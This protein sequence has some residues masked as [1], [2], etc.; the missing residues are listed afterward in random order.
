MAANKHR[1]LIDISGRRFG[2][3]VVMRR[4]GSHHGHALWQC[5]CDCGCVVEI[6]GTSLRRGRTTSCGCWFSERAAARAAKRN[7]R[8]G[9]R[10]TPG[11]LPGRGEGV[12]PR[13]L[14]RVDLVGAGVVAGRAQP[15]RLDGSSQRGLA[16]LREP[17]RLS[18]R[19]HGMQSPRRRV[20]HVTVAGCTAAPVAIDCCRGWLGNR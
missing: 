5:K 11:G 17:R 1:P 8:H 20:R 15:S 7:Y 4:V 12:H 18:E 19:E 14:S 13:E 9:W 16:E 10:E 2:R 3:L 6:P